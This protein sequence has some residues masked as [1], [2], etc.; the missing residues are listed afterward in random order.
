MVRFSLLDRSILYGEDP[1]SRSIEKRLTHCIQV[2]SC[3]REELKDYKDT[4][5]L[6][7]QFFERSLREI[8]EVL[9]FFDFVK[10]NIDPS[11]SALDIRA[12]EAACRSAS[13]GHRFLRAAA[14]QLRVVVCHNLRDTEH[15]EHLDAC[16]DA[17]T[18][19]LY[20]ISPLDKSS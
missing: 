12:V 18:G 11:L 7:L 19:A 15:F 20:N 9:R 16:E 2:V 17:L 5:D 13:V 14:N 4:E 10:N 8:K 1:N 3:I 6:Q